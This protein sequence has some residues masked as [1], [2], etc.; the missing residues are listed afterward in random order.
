MLKLNMKITKPWGEEIIY[1]PENSN[2]TF[3]QIK[4]NDNCR[5]SLQSHTEKT[6]TFVLIEGEAELT[7]GE[8]AQRIKAPVRM[9]IPPNVYH[10]LIALTDIKL[11]YY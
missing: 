5:I 6:E 1:T 9:E 7:I 10:K 8:E 4:I 3:K 2:Y 11:L